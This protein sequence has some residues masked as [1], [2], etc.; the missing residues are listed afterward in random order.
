[1][2]FRSLLKQ[3]DKQTEFFASNFALKLLKHLPYGFDVIRDAINELVEEGVLIVDGDK[4]Y[5]K[6]MVKDNYISELRSKAGS[7]GGKVTQFAKAK[8][9]AKG[10]AKHQ[11]NSEYENEIE[12]E[13]ESDN[14]VLSKNNKIKYHD[15]V[16][17]TELEYGKLC[18]G[19]GKDFADK[20]I[21]YLGNYKGSKGKTYKNDYRAI[22]SWVVDKVKEKNPKLAKQNARPTFVA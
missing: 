14:V 3:K 21:E 22:L 4:L 7:E 18:E 5:Q 9:Q 17:M 19:Y 15:F 13:S 20:C 8:S 12:I 1:M 2:L 16:S 10:K 11:A 6:R